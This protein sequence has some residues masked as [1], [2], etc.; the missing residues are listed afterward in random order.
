MRQFNGKEYV[1]RRQGIGELS[2]LVFVNSPQVDVLDKNLS[3]TSHERSDIVE[4]G[5]QIE[6]EDDVAVR[7]VPPAAREE[8]RPSVAS[9]HDRPT[10]K[11]KIGRRWR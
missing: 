10:A 1:K 8:E 7:S 5:D 4:S 11:S 6:G 9:I 3:L 2:V